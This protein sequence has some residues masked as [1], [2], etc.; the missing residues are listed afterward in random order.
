MAI[1]CGSNKK[2]AIT[3]CSGAVTPD[4]ITH[5]NSFQRAGGP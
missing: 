1:L 2:K 5:Q 4:Q 3:I